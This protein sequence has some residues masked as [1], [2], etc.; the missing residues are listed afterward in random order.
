[1]EALS[2]NT[3]L[4]ADTLDNFSHGNS[5]RVTQHTTAMDVFTVDSVGR[6]YAPAYA[7]APP[8][9][10]TKSHQGNGTLNTP[11]ESNGTVGNGNANGNGSTRIYDPNEDNDNDDDSLNEL[12]SRTT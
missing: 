5:Y 9:Y 2:A 12:E 6:N 8:P 7:A 3:T 1:M 11:E 10:T 4:G